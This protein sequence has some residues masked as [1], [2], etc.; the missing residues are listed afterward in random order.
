M[1]HNR[2]ILFVVG[3]R[4]VRFRHRETDCIGDPLSQ[5]TGCRFHAVRVMHFRVARCFAAELTE[6]LHIVHANGEAS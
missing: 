2:E 1:I 5:R 3:S 4:Q 6:V